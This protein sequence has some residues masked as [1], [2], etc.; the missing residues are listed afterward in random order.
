MAELEPDKITQPY[1]DWKDGQKA[2]KGSNNWL[3]FHRHNESYESRHVS[4]RKK[5]HRKLQQQR[6]GRN[7][8]GNYLC[9]YKVTH[10][11]G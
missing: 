4:K 1:Q 11:G 10:Q 9:R 2:D 6:P 7:P 3:R 5:D 8:K